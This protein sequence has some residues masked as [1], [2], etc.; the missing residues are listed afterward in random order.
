MVATIPRGGSPGAY[1]ST[2]VSSTTT[3]TL[4]VQPPLNGRIR[5]YVQKFHPELINTLAFTRN[6]D[7]E[8]SMMQGAHR[9]LLAAPLV[10]QDSKEDEDSREE[11][12][13]VVTVI[14]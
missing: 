5:R 1:F 3:T 12:L 6:R 9:R 14:D 10:D 4:P 8:K 13:D 11:D 2:A 7:A